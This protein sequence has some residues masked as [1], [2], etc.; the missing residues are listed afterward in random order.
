MKAIVD[1]SKLNPLS[2]NIENKLVVIGVDYFGQEYKE[3]KYQMVLACGGFG[4][5][6]DDGCVF[7]HEL[8][9]DNPEKYKRRRA[10]LVGEPTDEMINEWK[11]LYGEF[12]TEVLEKRIV[13]EGVKSDEERNKAN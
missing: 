10:E 3:A 7:V 11:E 9:N 5:R 8:H 1:E 4:C 2:E 6:Y 13:M 12:N